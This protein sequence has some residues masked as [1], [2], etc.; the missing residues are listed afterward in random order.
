MDINGS[1]IYETIVFEYDIQGD[2]ISF[3]RNVSNFIPCQIR[4]SNFSETLELAGKIMPDDVKRAIAFFRPLKTDKRER[5]EYFRCMDF[6]G[7]YPWYQASARTIMDGHGQ[8][9]L[10]Y[11]TYTL[12]DSGSIKSQEEIE[13]SADQL[14]GLDSI[15]EARR[16]VKE[17][18]D[19][20]EKAS[21]ASIMYIK[22]MDYGRVVQEY[23]QEHADTL[24]L[25]VSRILRRTLRATD[26]LGR[27]GRVSPEYAVEVNDSF[28]VCMRDVKDEAIFCDKA[29]FIIRA[30]K[31]LWSSFTRGANGVV[32]IGI[33]VYDEG[34][35]EFSFE[36]ISLKALEALRFAVVSGKDTFALYDDRLKGQK[37]LD[38]P[39]KPL[40]DIELIRSILNPIMARAYAVDENHHLLYMN[41]SLKERVV[42]ES[43][44]YC[45]EVLK[46]R[47]K[48][49]PD[50]PMLLMQDGKKSI[51]SEVYEPDLRSN[52]NMHTTRLSIGQIGTVYVMASLSGDTKD[53]MKR[54]QDSIS[55]FNECLYK[56]N[57]II[58]EINLT[59]NSATRVR[60][61]N[62][63]NLLASHVVNYEQLRKQY[64]DHVV[65][66]QDRSEFLYVT[67]PGYLRHAKKIGVEFVEKQVRFL[68][69]DGSWHWYLINTEMIPDGDSEGDERVFLIAKD[70]DR[71]KNEMQRKAVIESKMKAMA[72]NSSLLNEIQRDNERYEH[73][74]ELTGILVF[75]YSVPEKSYYICTTFEDIFK[76][77]PEMKR[78][79]W[80]LLEG[81]EIHELDRDRYE[82][83][84]DLVKREP[85]T[86]VTTLRFIN[87]FGVSR[88]FTLTV[89]TLNGLNNQ[90]ARVTGI[91]QD[92]NNEMEIKAELEFRADYDSVTKLYNS[93]AF[94]RTV[95][96][97][98]FLYPE[99]K[100]AIIGIDIEHFRIINDRFGVD[101][102]NKC[103]LELGTKI[104]MSL[105]K[106]G[107]AGRYEA[108][109]FSV[110][111]PYQT[112]HD[113]IEYITSLS[114]SFDVEAAKQ[115]GST[116]SFGIYKVSNREVP[117]RLMCDRAR[118]AKK[119]IKGNML[120]NFAVYDDKIRLM[121]RKIAQMEGEMQKA[122]D[123]EEFVMYL[124]PKVDLKT[125]KIC[126][127]E[128]LVR[129]EHPTRGL[130]MPGEFLPLFESNGFVKKLDEYMWRC[131]AKYLAKLSEMGYPIPISVN[132]SRLH[133][134][135]TDLVGVLT[136][137][138]D[139]YSI[140][141]RLMELEITE[142]LFTEDVDKLYSTMR[143]LKES[144]FMILMDDFGS[145]YSSLNMLREA[146]VDVI[147]IDRYFVDEIMSTERGRIIVTH[148][149]TMSKQLG[150][151]VVAEGV[152]TREQADFLRDADCDVAQG[153]FYSKPVPVE[154]FEKM[155][156]SGKIF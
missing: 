22:L 28:L 51:H 8:P 67:D 116:L 47:D 117:I 37:D 66:Y 18:F 92:V 124:Q 64:L 156:L 150:M 35:S 140:D 121:Q 72:D 29:H 19:S 128:A 81:L 152:E 6:N 7:K 142:T 79:Q 60:E 24:V 123:N 101:T 102:G 105:P 135:N 53:E 83:F 26:I 9:A 87:R 80:S 77:T 119:E 44:G 10:L 103:L 88:W 141:K 149:I 68:Q 21:L 114:D 151:Q 130:R 75:E 94:Y 126:G 39:K 112:D 27:G 34:D 125:E 36:R 2:V 17:Y 97:E 13:R 107:I 62:V 96:E 148:S 1:T 155:L 145:G 133:I 89:Q 61:E 147:K 129:W 153:Y 5:T 136:G 70:I 143:D 138:T 41:D 45:Y 58:W 110:L 120:T 55:L 76:L 69:R 99:K 104:S 127:A 20:R 144:G 52:I 108:D 25:D 82:A 30:V 98:I 132:I 100:F 78:D 16:K 59:T 56:S 15:E 3:S 118:L 86:H 54:I 63:M 95:R 134:N 74:N 11:G 71:L 106:L 31:T 93:E 46:G 49:C 85:D 32:S 14:T 38:R 42:E 111:L 73:V 50:C 90:L 137:L 84:L 65:Y 23:G 40:S 43:E 4:I 115:C 33:G 57:D 146:P 139:E 131:T 91:L 12:V 48:P 113:I 154:Q 109:M 122:L